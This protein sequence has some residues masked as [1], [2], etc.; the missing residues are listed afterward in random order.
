MTQPYVADRGCLADASDLIAR[1]G[2]DAGFEA[3][4]RADRSRDRGNLSHFCRWRQIE[5]LIVL[6]SD[7]TARG[8]VH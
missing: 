5:R 1:F 6:L 3:A 7:Q 4:A 2:A 8:T